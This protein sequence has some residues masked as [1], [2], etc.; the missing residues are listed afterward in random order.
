MSQS[1]FLVL[2]L[3]V[4][5]TV[6]VAGVIALSTKDRWAAFWRGLITSVVLLGTYHFFR[7]L[8]EVA[9]NENVRAGDLIWAGF[10]GLRLGLG[11]GG[12]VGLAVGYT[13]R[14]VVREKTKKKW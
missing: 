2:Y 8:V 1:E 7:Q 14:I 13:A 11:L 3:P 9:Q 10:S 6:I 4:I 12:L 5:I